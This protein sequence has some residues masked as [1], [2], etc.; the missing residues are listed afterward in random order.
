LARNH[1]TRLE[2]SNLFILLV[3][4]AVPLSIWFLPSIRPFRAAQPKPGLKLLQ[5]G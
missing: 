5:S 3:T 4:S 1:R 2:T